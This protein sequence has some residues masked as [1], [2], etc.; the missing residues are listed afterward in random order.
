MKQQATVKSR[1]GEAMN[2]EANTITFAFRKP[3]FPLICDL[4]GDLFAALSAAALQRRLAGV[5]LAD[6]KK[7]RFVD[8]SGEGWMFLAEERIL[9]PVFPMSRWRKIEVIRLFNDSRNA[10][11]MGVH[12]PERRLAN[13]RFDMIVREIVALLSGP[14]KTEKERQ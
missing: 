9:A 7:A 8:A 4:D 11:D 3:R 13:R 5:E 2:S 14:V 10:R 6:E 1:T 12:Y